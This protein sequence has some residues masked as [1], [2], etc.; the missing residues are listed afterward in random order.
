MGLAVQDG[1]QERCD[2]TVV[3]Q[4][5]VDCLA[6]DEILD[7]LLVALV[8]RD[9]E[10]CLTGE[11]LLVDVDVGGGEQ[12]GE[13]LDVPRVGG[14]HQGGLSIQ[15]SGTVDVHPFIEE[16]DDLADITTLHGPGQGTL[17]LTQSNFLFPPGEPRLHSRGFIS[18]VWSCDQ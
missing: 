4:V 7:K 16:V 17:H 3:S 15:P 8:G 12:E 2:P 13:D 11:I 5:G 18:T 1:G 10:G 14:Q 9:D 6:R